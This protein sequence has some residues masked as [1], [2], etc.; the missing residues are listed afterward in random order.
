MTNPDDPLL[1]SD[2]LLRPHLSADLAA[3]DPDPFREA[4][5]LMDAQMVGTLVEYQTMT[6][7]VLFD[8]RMAYEY[9]D[10]NVGVLVAR[11]LTDLTLFSSSESP[12]EVWAKEV[13]YIEHDGRQVTVVIESYQS[14]KFSTRI[15]GFG[16]EF[17]VG[18]AGRLSPRIA[19]FEPG[20]LREYLADF[21]GWDDRITLLYGAKA[22]MHEDAPG[23][24]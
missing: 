2:L 4:H 19:E 22:A 24:H 13:A 11:D 17:Y 16:L 12:S 21:P 15:A 8:L 14:G 10:A 1:V 5:A 6:A 23:G 7:A 18:V 3:P 20:R 9:R